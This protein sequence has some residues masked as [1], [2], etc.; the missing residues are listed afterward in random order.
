M[1]A[2]PIAAAL[3]E[4]L[5]VLPIPDHAVPALP[6]DEEDDNR[7]PDE[8][9][10]AIPLE[11]FPAAGAQRLQRSR[12][13]A[14]RGGYLED[15]PDLDDERSRPLE[16]PTGLLEL[17]HWTA[18]LVPAMLEAAAGS[19]P[20]PQLMRWVSPSVYDA[21]VRRHTRAARRGHAVRRPLRIVRVILQEPTPAIVEATVVFADGP[22]VRA[23]A[24]RFMPVNRR[25]VAEA[26]EVG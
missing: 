5:R 14:A 20:T 9:Q 13:P 16:R 12:L 8:R 18:K 6:V 4:P 15:D 26:F 11:M 23:A 17:Q 2:Q 1:S 22:R 10:L 3:V 19:R 24:L 21:L 25:W 7:H